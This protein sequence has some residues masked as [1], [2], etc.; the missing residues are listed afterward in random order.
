MKAKLLAVSLISAFALSAC[1]G[2][3]SS[4]SVNES[5]N[6]EKPFELKQQAV[7]Y[8]SQN[9]HDN[10]GRYDT[11]YVPLFLNTEPVLGT[12][13][14]DNI[15][16]SDYDK[17]TENDDNI[18][19]DI[20]IAGRSFTIVSNNT[21]TTDT[22]ITTGVKENL[23]FAPTKGSRGTAYARY[24]KNIV[25]FFD[26]DGSA[27]ER[28]TLT[29]FGQATADM[30][31]TGIATYLGYAMAEDMLHYN[32]QIKNLHQ[33]GQLMYSPYYGLSEFKVDFT[34]KKLTGTLNDWKV[35]STFASDMPA[36][37]AV[38]I[39][40]KIQANTFKGTANGSGT[41]EGKFYGPKA[42]NLAGAFNDKSQNLQGVFGA[43]KQ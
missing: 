17:W 38:N 33:N 32:E 12:V 18:A 20:N 39:D 27:T 7:T 43:N 5:V 19:T 23:I 22:G 16:Q 8:I 28:R 9:E 1:G 21:Q 40:A 26:I 13:N 14:E 36:K 37:K 34:N 10:E 24:G 31:K 2:G 25:T 29:Y 42:Q 4:V 3:G 41:A 30:P 11:E 35:N 6:N 15:K